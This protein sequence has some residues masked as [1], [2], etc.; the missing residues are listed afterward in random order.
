MGDPNPGAEYNMS[1]V[2]APVALFYA[3]NDLFVFPPVSG[4]RSRLR[5]TR[6]AALNLTLLGL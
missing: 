3:P 6:R 1:A 2:T 5:P 4:S